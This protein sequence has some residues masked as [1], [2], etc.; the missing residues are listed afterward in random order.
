LREQAEYLRL[1]LAMGL[2]SPDAVV[3]WADRVIDATDDPPIE[4]I[5]VS[6]SGGRSPVEV[7]DLLRLVP[8]AGDLGAAAHRALGL[9]RRRVRDG[10]VPSDRAAEMLWAYSNW[11]TVPEDERLWAVNLTDAVECLH[12]GYGTPDT[13]R[14]EILAFLDQHATVP[15]DEPSG[16]GRERD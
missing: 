4:V 15:S 10:S 16:P 6:L 3:V 7:M 8:G 1:A 14:S 9:L 2:I 11:A 12:L 5:E 13:V